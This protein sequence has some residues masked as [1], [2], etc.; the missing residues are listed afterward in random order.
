MMD[1]MLEPLYNFALGELFFLQPAVMCSGDFQVP[2]SLGFI[3][4][5]K[6]AVMI[7]PSL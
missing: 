7:G 2:L 3:A 6:F 5:D 4:N 1:F